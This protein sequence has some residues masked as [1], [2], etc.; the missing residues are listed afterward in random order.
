MKKVTKR[1]A[2]LFHKAAVV[3]CGTAS[4]NGSHQPVAP[5]MLKARLGK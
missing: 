5:T 3:A 4:F 1:V 2:K